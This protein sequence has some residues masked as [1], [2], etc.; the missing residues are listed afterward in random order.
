MKGESSKN[1][2]FIL[3]IILITGIFFVISY[4]AFLSYSKYQGSQHSTN[5]MAF[6]SKVNT[7]LSKIEKEQ[8]YS[9]IF[10]GSKKKNDFIKV[11]S[12]RNLVNLEIEVISSFLDRNSE[13]SSYKRDI[14][15][16]F[17]NLNYA[18]SRV[19][20]A[21]QE[22]NNILFN[23][24][25][26]GV[27]QPL[28]SV[29]DK[30][31]NH[32]FYK[33]DGKL[34]HYITLSKLKENLYIENSFISFIL[35]SSKVMTD[36]DLLLWEKMLEKDTSPYFNDLG[37][38][39][40]I[41]KLNNIIKQQKFSYMLEE[42]RGEI[43]LDSLDGD[44]RVTI[45][46]WVNRSTQKINLVADAQVVLLLEAVESIEGEVASMKKRS[47]NLAVSAIFIFIILTALIYLF[48]NNAKN[49]RLLVDT[50]KDI[51]SDLDEK[52][53]NDIQEVL[54]KND[55]MEIYKFLANAIK[56]PSRAKDH[57]L[58]NMSHEIRTPL[59]GIIGFTHI[60]KETEL[61][62]EQREFLN[63][64]E[65]SSHN[66]ISIVNDI[67]D[68]SKASSGKV[69]F[70]N[71]PFNVMEKFEASIDSYSAKAAQKNI[72]LDLFIDPVLP[73]ELKGDS[74]KISQVIINLLSNAI[75]FT[76]EGG[77]VSV[78]ID[79]VSES[80]DSVSLKFSVKDSG[81]G[82]SDVQKAKIFDAFSQAD[83]STSRRFGGTGLG[84]TISSKFVSL[85]GGQLEV[86]SIKGEGATFFFSL[87]LHKSR[88]NKERV[89]PD[90]LSN[91]KVAYVGKENDD[92][93]CQNLKDYITYIGADF[94]AYSHSE[95]LSIDQSLLPDIIFLDYQFIRD[96]SII[97]SIIA[98]DTKSILI[99][100][101]EVDTLRA[102]LKESV[103]KI[104]Y[105]PINYSKTLRSLKLAK[106]ENLSLEQTFTKVDDR[107]IDE[108]FT[109]INALVVEDNII[110]Q[111]LIQRILYNFNIGVT[112][113]QN[114]KDAL[115]L[116]KE[117]SYDIIFMDI[118]MP[119]MDGVEATKRIIA[120]EKEKKLD[121]IPIV[122]LTANTTKTDRDKY[123]AI[124]MDR[125]LKKPIDVNA[126]IN[127]LEDYFPIHELREMM[128]LDR[129]NS[130]SVEDKLKIILYKETPLT[131]KIYAAVLNNLGYKVDS[132]SS[133]SEFLEQLDT[134]D[135]K[136]ALFD[137]KPFKRVN[138]DNF[139]VDLIRD[140]GA[141]PIAFVESYQSTTPC[142]TL[143]PI[144]N[145]REISQ[146]LKKCS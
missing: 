8:S 6:I 77:R 41:F 66:L 126:L 49:S 144:G 92:S 102:S 52:Q 48:R 18:R 120:Y 128:P 82:I 139:V 27:M 78:R 9:A 121:H 68:F 29:M 43:F 69:E 87:N 34:S 140:S 83:A 108:A 135:Y 17:K 39:A 114:G 57:F 116:R 86:E 119:V 51:E 14:K 93:V 105:K 44:Y 138:S 146:T 90:H 42:M 129:Q 38:L 131:A 97:E 28:I 67:L 111:K 127:I 65:E 35:S 143:K 85:M 122:T 115:Q 137:A 104:L 15:N 107:K 141:T 70:E 4:Y 99:S 89:A 59:N 112:I 94:S 125:Y 80:D 1:I 110:N 22:Y 12:Y 37:D 3:G 31:I 24:Y 20:I 26:K 91:L 55:T 10:I 103:S 60:L 16:V 124:G 13:F 113:A 106:T 47:F 100:T 132:F 58:A 62:E 142:E 19:D 109:N 79:K 101:A 133:E 145:V 73:I 95:I 61:K 88:D 118:Q 56:E 21:N 36:K 134:Q 11:K 50:L 30:L 84:L 76:E 81:I 72:G 33:N 53:R 54:K 123:L 136:F 130:T 32:T 64:I 117:N 40:T 5:H 46:D 75:K 25:F 96:E 2:S 23:S 74:T 63:I 71:I 7:L 45:T 98:L